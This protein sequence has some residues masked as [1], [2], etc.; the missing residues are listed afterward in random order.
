[1]E[2][3]KSGNALRCPLC[4]GDLIWGGDAMASEICDEYSE[5]DTAVWSNYTCSV[6]GRYYEIYEPNEDERKG[7]YCGYWDRQKQ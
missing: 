6:C 3:E 7:E 2:K 5:E 4:G 1:M